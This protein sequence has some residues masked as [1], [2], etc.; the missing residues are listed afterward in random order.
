MATKSGLPYPKREQ[1]KPIKTPKT[2]KVTDTE[3]NQEAPIAD[4]E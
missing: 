3:N 1:P 4:N 2:P